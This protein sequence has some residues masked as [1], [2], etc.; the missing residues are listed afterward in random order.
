MVRKRSIHHTS[1]SSGSTESRDSLKLSPEA[2]QGI[3]V[4]YQPS[5]SSLGAG[6]RETRSTHANYAQ[7][8]GSQSEVPG[9]AEPAQV[10]AYCIG[11]SVCKARSLF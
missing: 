4:Y 5:E 10:A 11:I 9:P 3:W 1:G 8:S 7:Y 2:L 6:P